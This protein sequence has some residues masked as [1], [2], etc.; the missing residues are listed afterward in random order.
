MAQTQKFSIL[1]PK[2]LLNEVRPVGILEKRSNRPSGSR[3]RNFAGPLFRRRK[4][5]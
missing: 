5:E 2:I 4:T 3:T 1:K